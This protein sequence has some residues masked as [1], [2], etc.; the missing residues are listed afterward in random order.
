MILELQN[1]LLTIHLPLILPKLLTSGEGGSAWGASEGVM[2]QTWPWLPNRVP[3]PPFL[4]VLRSLWGCVAP[5][6]QWHG[7]ASPS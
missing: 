4:T 7:W 6:V 5:D 3:A 1:S 2:A